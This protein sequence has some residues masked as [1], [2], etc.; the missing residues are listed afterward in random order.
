MAVDRLTFA[1]DFDN[2][3]TAEPLLFANFIEDCKNLGHKVIVVTARRDTEENFDEVKSWLLENGIRAAVYYSSLRSKTELMKA[4]GIKVD[5]WIDD[6][7]HSL[8]N[9]Y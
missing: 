9:G 6:D 8:V 4:R 5:I 2:T 3:I 1:I 7:P